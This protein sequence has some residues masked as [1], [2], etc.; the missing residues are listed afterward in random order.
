M[1]L[2]RLELHELAL[3]PD[4]NMLNKYCGKMQR[5]LVLYTSR[6]MSEIN[7]LRQKD[8]NCNVMF[9]ITTTF[10]IEYYFLHFR[11]K[12]NDHSYFMVQICIRNM[13]SVITFLLM[14]G[15]QFL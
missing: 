14:F 12:I 15:S 7:R 1:C 6:G 8:V 13:I 5:G 3:L 9:N 10:I 11:C 2:S 4:K